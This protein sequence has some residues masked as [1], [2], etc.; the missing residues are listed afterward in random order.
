MADFGQGKLRSVGKLRSA[1]IA[2]TILTSGTPLLATAAAP[3]ANPVRQFID[4]N[5]VDVMRGTFKILDPV[6]TVGPDNNTGLSFDSEAGGSFSLLNSGIVLSGP[7]NTSGTV[8]YV[9][10][11][12]VT[13]SFTFTVNGFVSTEGSGAELVKTSAVY[14]YSSS[15]GTEAQFT[16]NVAPGQP[17]YDAGFAQLRSITRVNGTKTTISYRGVKYCPGGTEEGDFGQVCPPGY[18][19]AVRI[20]GLSNNLG[21][22]IKFSYVSN[23]LNDL[24]V[25]QSYP[26]W[27]SLTQAQGINGNVELCNPAADTCVLNGNWPKLTYSSIAGARTVT[28]SLGRTTQY[29]IVTNASGAVTA[30]KVKR[31]GASNDNVI[32]Y[33]DASNRVSSVVNEN[34]TFSYS[35]A[36]TL[37]YGQTNNIRTTTVTHPAGTEV[38]TSN[39]T[40][41]RIL[42]YR[43]ELLRTTAYAYDA[44]GRV[45]RVTMPEGNYTEYTYDARG[46]RTQTRAVAKAGSGHPDIVTTATYPP[47]CANLK[48]CN[49]PTTTIDAKGNVAEYAYDPTHGSL[50]SAKAPASTI[51]GVRPE[52]RYGFTAI[53][54]DTGSVYRL[55]STS[56]CQTTASCVGTSDE[57][58]SSVT[59][60]TTG[61]TRFNP[62][63]VSSGAGDGTLT[64]TTAVTYDSVGNTISVDGPLAGTADTSVAVY[65]AARQTIGVIGPDPD[66]A[67]AL[68]NRAQRMTY[69]LDGQVTKA[70]AGTTVGQTPAAFAAFAPLQQTIAAYDANARKTSDT[71][72]VGSTSYGLTQY[73]YDALGR[74]DCSAVRMNIAVYSSLPAACT[75]STLG[76]AGPDRISKTIYN[77]ASQVTKVQSAVGTADQSDEIATA[78]NL[79]GTT[80]TMADANGNLTTIIYDGFDRVSQTRFPTAGNGAVSSTTDYEGATYDANGNVTQRRLR[81]GQLINFTYDNL[82][83]VTL[84]DTPN[85]AYMDYDITYQYDLLGRSTR[86]TNSAG[87]VNAFVYDALG[88]ITTEQMYGSTTTYAYDLAGRRT[89]MTWLDGFYVLYN[90]HVTGDVFNIME[91]GQSTGPGVLG[92]YFYNDLGQ[93]TGLYRGNGAATLYGYDPVGRL[94]HLV[95]DLGGTAHDASTTFTYNPASQIASITRDND[96]YKWNG[97]YNIDRPY[98]V[99][100]LNQLTTAGSVALGYD[101]RGNLTSSG[102]STYSYTSENRLATSPQT[103]T[104]LGYE[105]SGNQ[106]LQLYQ[107]GTATDTRFGWSGGAMISEMNAA[108]GGTITRR[109]VHGPG[110]DAPL[111]WYEGAG[112]TDKRWLIP[113]ER[114]SIVAVTNASGTVT[115]VNS[116]DE[117]GIPASTNLGRFQYTGQAWLPEIGMYY[118]KARIYSPTLGRFMQTD[119]IGYGDGMNMYNYVSGDPINAR[120]PSG[121]VAAAIKETPVQI[122]AQNGKVADP[123][124]ITITAQTFSERYQAFTGGLEAFQSFRDALAGVGFGSGTNDIADIEGEEIVVTAKR[125][126]PAPQAP[127]IRIDF[128]PI[129]RTPE[130]K[131][132]ENYPCRL[133]RNSKGAG[134]YL[135]YIA[136]TSG[137]A[138]LVPTPLSPELATLAAFT[139]GVGGVLSLG[140]AVGEYFLCKK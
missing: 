82:N 9:T 62:V 59:Y 91:N 78:Y 36:D 99:N 8:Y 86:A 64:A 68:K 49:K 1:L 84:K 51:G 83:R 137:G 112:T 54:A 52:V 48:T 30:Q 41:F 55:T 50:T 126:K 122:A 20:Q 130:P 14:V 88:R 24:V 43:D 21:Y 76:S 47:T 45:T 44:T 101:G 19:T 80:A 129:E 87:H 77:A 53:A 26:E 114:G 135:G 34:V 115:A 107:G 23:G 92:S 39:T 13:D 25:G 134:E 69:N 132:Q 123:N 57:V 131:S 70:E 89:R 15:D 138:A 121:R 133:S 97:H 18:R 119:P 2:T 90:R 37:G 111:V 10:V 79:N 136:T 12:T 95:Q 102:S 72:Q 67:G 3:K 66:G 17:Y 75:A 125:E 85:V 58:K 60:G 71:L 116:Y 96:I 22:V 56:V 120:D 108:T 61:A 140:G 98:T 100:G 40:T 110:A 16:E 28:D 7:A 106:I 42:S 11:G 63:A 46:N 4:R 65:D 32:A 73:S 29:P 105:P 127:P 128:R 94:V 139:G 104:Y 117:Y 109:Y 113:D 35:Y 5:G 38:Y 93:L 6:I 27:S 33:R 118:Y 124:E 81:D 31:P 74:L 103:T